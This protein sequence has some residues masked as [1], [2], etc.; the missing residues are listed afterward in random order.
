M[1]VLWSSSYREPAPL[2][3]PSVGGARRVVVVAPFSTVNIEETLSCVEDF[4]IISA[5]LPH[6]PMRSYLLHPLDYRP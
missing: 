2:T 4:N 3:P 1:I 5:P 6:H